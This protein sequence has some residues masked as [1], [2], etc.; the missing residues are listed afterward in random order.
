M[1]GEGRIF[2]CL[3]I[4]ANLFFIE[5]QKRHKVT[6]A[7]FFVSFNFSIHQGQ[8]QRLNYHCPCHCLPRKAQ[9]QLWLVKGRR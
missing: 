8:N 5:C 9:E 7:V 4:I 2:S 6:E 3:S 1:K